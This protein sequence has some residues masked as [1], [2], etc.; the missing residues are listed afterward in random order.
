[1]RFYLEIHIIMLSIIVPVFNHSNLTKNTLENIGN[2]CKEIDYEVIVINDGSTDDTNELL[3]NIELLKIVKKLRIK[4]FIN[5]RGVT[6]A[7]NY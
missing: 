1:M 6:Q 7:W 2:I 5:N 4:T 3:E